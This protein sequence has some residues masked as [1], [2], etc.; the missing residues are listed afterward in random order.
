MPLTVRERITL[1]MMRGYGDKERSY[2]EVAD[3]FNE[4]YPDRGIPIS[5]ST[6]QKTVIRFQRTGKVEDEAR[7]GRPKTATNDEEALNVMLSVVESPETSTRK[8]GHQEE[9]SRRS[10]QRILNKHKYH[11]YKMRLVQELS[12]DDFDRRVEF[13][14]EMMTRYVENNYF[15]FW[16][17]FS[18]EATFELN[19]KVNR[20]N[21]RYWADS[22]PYWMRDTHTQYNAKVNVWAGIL[23][24]RIVGPFF[25][26][27]TL[28]AQRYLHLLRDRIIPAIREI[29]GELFENVWFQQDGAPPHFGRNVR[30][31]LDETFPHRW[32]GRRGSIEWPARSPDLTPL[33]FFYWGYLK[34]RVYAT[35]P[36]CI[37]DLKER[38]LMVSQSVTPEMLTNVSNTLY[39]RFGH[40]QAVN[41]QQFEHLI[42]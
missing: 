35:K 7:S 25:L 39:L 26:D 17:C 19:G 9:M 18:D 6:V 28:N 10:V 13:C 34:D 41:G 31:Y 30:E 8:L 33:D 40:C 2:Q 23:N 3:L 16:T 12:E 4:T 11:P 22:N 42:K 14:D 27:E 37:N 20:H 36:V 32:I 24:N 38:I 5:K 29:V 15:F 21:M 1:L